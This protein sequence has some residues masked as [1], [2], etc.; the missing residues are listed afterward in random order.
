M[1]KAKD[2]SKLYARVASDLA[3]ALDDVSS[4][5]VSND[6]GSAHLAN[7]K[8]KLSEM[9]A[10]FDGEISYLEEHAEWDKFTIAFFGE[11]NAGKSTIIE[12][13]RILFEEKKR[14]ALIKKNQATA[15][16]IEAVFSEKSDEL[17]DEL[18]TRYIS[19]CEDIASL[20]DDIGALV[21]QTQRDLQSTRQQLEH[22]QQEYND[23]KGRLSHVLS[24]LDSTRQ[25]L[26]LNETRLEENQRLLSQSQR[27]L[28]LVGLQLAERSLQLEECQHEA[29]ATRISLDHRAKMRL[30]FGLVAG[31]AIGT[32]A[33]ALGYAQWLSGHSF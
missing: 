6:K 13:L 26:N 2:F 19:F 32:V 12:S 27:E 24:E 14:Q 18:S 22:T 4:L 31:A 9:K 5:D 10:R 30:V 29:K 1:S 25:S 23:C 15:N 16:D 28:E 7:V 20:G 8:G 3:M 21:N 17:I 11:T 33:G